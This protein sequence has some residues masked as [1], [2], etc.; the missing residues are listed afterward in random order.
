MADYFTQE[1]FDHNDGMCPQHGAFLE[2]GER[3]GVVVF[4]CPDCRMELDSGRTV[5]CK[6]CGK[7]I[8]WITTR[9]KKSMPVDPGVTTV[10][11][12]DGVTVQGSR[13]HW[14]TCTDAEAHRQAPADH[15]D[16]SD[17]AE[18]DSCLVC[19]KTTNYREGQPADSGDAF[20]QWWCPQRPSHGWWWKK[21]GTRYK[22]KWRQRR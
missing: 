19:G 8:K 16:G 12:K 18:C 21:K 13:P 2:Q 15:G 5:P 6:S 1:Q 10:I 22:P 14:A 17:R 7:P 3:D 20:E 9:N 11:T 4:Y